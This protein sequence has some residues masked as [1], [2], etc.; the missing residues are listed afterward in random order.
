MQQGLHSP[1]FMLARAF[2][3]QRGGFT[4]ASLLDQGSIKGLL[5]LESAA[6]SGPT[7]GGLNIH[8]SA[9]INLR[10]AHFLPE[11]LTSIAHG[12]HSCFVCLNIHNLVSRH[13]WPLQHSFTRTHR[14]NQNR[15]SCASRS[16]TKHINNQSLGKRLWISWRQPLPA[17]IKICGRFY[18]DGYSA[19]LRSCN[20]DW[21]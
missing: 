14:T 10:G 8:S 13:K 2:P 21:Q 5:E 3:E 6:G 4:R 19:Q 9:I 11:H 17:Q 12:L 16:G 1:G 15:D 20:S 7:S 18:S